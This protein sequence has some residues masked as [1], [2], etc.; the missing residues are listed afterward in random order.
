MALA[1]PTS[2]GSIPWMHA[3]CINVNALQQA[4]KKEADGWNNRDKMFENIYI[5]YS[6][7]KHISKNSSA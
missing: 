2:W 5:I 3:K 6:I 4:Q 1:K 7:P